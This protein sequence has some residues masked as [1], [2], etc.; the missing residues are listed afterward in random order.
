MYFGVG[1]NVWPGP[2]RS[3]NDWFYNTNEFITYIDV[4]S[5]RIFSYSVLAQFSRRR[6]RMA[7]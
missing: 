3:Y 6:K 2:T 5:L 4:L 1:K 7:M